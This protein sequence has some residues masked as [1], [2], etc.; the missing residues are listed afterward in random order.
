M[1]PNNNTKRVPWFMIPYYSDN[2]PLINANVIIT[3]DTVPKEV[4]DTKKLNY[5]EQQI[6][7]GY[8]SIHK[9]GSTAARKVAFKLELAN[10]NNDVGLGKELAQFDMLRRPYINAY[11]TVTNPNYNKPI[12]TADPTKIDTSPTKKDWDFR[13]KPFQ[14]NPSVIYYHSL[15]NTIPL[16]FRVLKCDFTTSKPNRI[17][18][19]Q[20]AVVDIELVEMEESTWSLYEDKVKLLMALAATV[21]NGVNIL[22]NLLQKTNTRNV[23]KN[24]KFLTIGI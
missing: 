19:P 15:F 5:Y 2:E 10:F 6:P 4:T 21:N 20:Y 18:R 1:T 9:Y 22:K 3:S 13:Y 12:D 16:A 14:S 23:Y 11:S 24:S 17:G 8:T 7:G